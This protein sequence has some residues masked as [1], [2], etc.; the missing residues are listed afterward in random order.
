MLFRTATQ[1][2]ITPEN[3]TYDG[4][5]TPYTRRQRH[6]PLRQEA[7]PGVEASAQSTTTLTYKLNAQPFKIWANIEKGGSTFYTEDYT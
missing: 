2:N 3:E 6:A 4:R 5:N 1:N 7:P